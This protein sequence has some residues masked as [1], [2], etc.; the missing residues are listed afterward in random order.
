MEWASFAYETGPFNSISEQGSLTIVRRSSTKKSQQNNGG[1]VVPCPSSSSLADDDTL[2]AVDLATDN[3][4]AVDTPDA[5][6]KAAISLT[7]EDG[8]IELANALVVLSKTAEDGE[9]E[10][11][12]SAGLRCLLRQL[13]RGEISAE[14]L[15]KNL[16]YAARVLEAVFIDETKERGEEPGV[17]D[18]DLK[19]DSAPSSSPSARDDGGGGAANTLLVQ[20][21]RLRTPVWAR[22]LS[23]PPQRVVLTNFNLWLTVAKSPPSQLYL[24]TVCRSNKELLATSTNQRCETCLIFEGRLT[25]QKREN[26][27]AVSQQ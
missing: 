12:I 17:A 13:Q 3:L 22:S 26:D 19:H 20:K 15:Q 16:H 7:A 2:D 21:R 1:S 25:T 18:A 9:I 8:E 5:C 24:K 10:V 27:N 6:D 14:L 23:L 4:P 11:R